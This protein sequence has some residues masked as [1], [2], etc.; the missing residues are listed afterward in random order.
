MKGNRN[1]RGPV[2]KT[3]LKDGT[4]GRLIRMIFSFYPVLLPFTLACIL[5]N[6]IITAIPSLFQQRIIALI[7]QNWQSGDWAGVSARILSLVLTL[8]VLYVLSLIAGTTYNQC[9]AVIT[10]GSLKKIRTKMFDGMQKL[11][12]SYFDHNEHGD[13]MSYYTN[14]VDALRQMISQSIP[15]LLNS[16]IILVTVFSLMLY[17]SIWLTILVVGGIVVMTKVVKKVGGSSGR[18][19]VKQQAAVA[20]T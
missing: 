15:Q 18:Y 9:M 14:D 19:F 17:Y 1:M 7:E 13:I 20:Q 10:Q 2:D 3:V 6:A 5:V 8:A 4:L 16:G 12:I 11:P